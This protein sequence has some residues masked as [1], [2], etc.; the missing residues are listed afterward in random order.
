MNE[1]PGVLESLSERVEKLERRVHALENP[2]ESQAS[3]PAQAVAESSAPFGESASSLETDKVFPI[4]GRAML[5]IAG[6]YVFRAVAE[7][8]ML[9]RLAVSAV[10]VAYAF[11]WLVWSSRVSSRL[12]RIVYAATSALILAPMLWESTLTFHTFSS[13]TSA[14]VLA[15]FLTLATIL[16]RRDGLRSL[17]IAQSIAALTT[18]ALAFTTH[19]AFP[20]VTALLIVVSVSEYARTRELSQPAWPLLVVVTDI[21]IAGLI[22]IYSGPQDARTA[23]PELAVAAL[24]APASTLFALNGASVVVRV[25]ANGK[26]TSIFD[27][28]QMMIAF[29]FAVAATLLFA[30]R[31]VAIVLGILSLFVSIA[32]YVTAFRSLRHRDEQ[33]SFL[34]FGTWSA[35]LLLLGSLWSL[36]RPVAA[37]VLAIAAVGAE[38]LAARM[39][40][41]MLQFHGALFL[42]AAAIVAGLPQYIYSTVA[43]DFPRQV[44]LSVLVVAACTAW[45]FVLTGRTMETARK[46]LLHFVLALLATCALTAVLVQSVLIAAAAVSIVLDP[47]HVAFLRTL[48]ICL[49]A[50]AM[51]FGGSRWARTELTYL[52]Y[53]ALAF[54]AA[55]LLL[56]D[57]RH[58]H[59]EFIAG[60]I[61]L[62]AVTLIAVPRLARLGTRRRHA[63]ANL[64]TANSRKVIGARTG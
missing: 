47:H 45:S 20:F 27:T 6:A 64:E 41:G 59:M 2:N 44:E 7:A 9:P 57:L 35:A 42:I 50:L 16:E 3:R 11:G 34:A 51:A 13:M 22:F 43:G 48:T 36:P 53:V 46:K 32:A 40:S 28:V 19:D 4:I 30:Q 60:S 18:V 37:I 21:A 8:G 1:S 14:G 26:Q 24:I 5:G 15:S 49:S 10:A 58:G 63:I 12:T 33:R 54:V 52:A 39:E 17:W 38:F 62:F 31:H 23:Y 61:A 29:L 56:D 25:V 55:K